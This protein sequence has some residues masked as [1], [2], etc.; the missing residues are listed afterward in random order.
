[1]VMDNLNRI[2]L[3]HLKTLAILLEEQHV[4]HAAIRLNITQAA[5]SATLAKMRDLFHDPLLVRTK[6]GMQPTA[7][8]LNMIPQLQALLHQTEKIVDEFTAFDPLEMEHTV[9]IG[10]SDTIAELLVP[11]LEGV[12]AQEA[13][14]LK[15]RLLIRN[16]LQGIEEFQTNKL[17]LA[18]NYYASAPENL[19]KQLVYRDHAVCLMRDS[20]KYLQGELTVEK[21]QQARLIMLSYK[22]E[23]SDSNLLSTLKNKNVELSPA[24]VTPLFSTALST[25]L[26]SDAIFFA[27]KKLAEKV[28]RYYPLRFK[29]PNIKMP[30]R[31]INQYWAMHLDNANWHKWLRSRVKA[32]LSE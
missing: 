11:K 2:N 4:S 19:K 26:E 6:M 31:N 25:I 8:A 20:N 1:M 3:N 17:H 21:L 22:D 7:L 29:E 9:R 28:C 12:L 15:L 32:I 18:I 23:W 14:K 13:P 10:L 16:Y 5:V 27:P 24:I 30:T